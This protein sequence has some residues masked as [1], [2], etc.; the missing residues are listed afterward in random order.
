MHKPTTTDVVVSVLKTFLVILL[1]AFWLKWLMGKFTYVEIETWKYPACT[2]LVAVCTPRFLHGF[3]TFA[4]SLGTA[5]VLL[6][7]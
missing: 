1:S 4:L 2:L 3:V 5:Y 6:F 7:K